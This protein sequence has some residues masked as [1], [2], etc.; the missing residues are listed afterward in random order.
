MTTNG[1]GALSALLLV[2]GL[3][4]A[5][6]AAAPPSAS[7]ASYR[8]ARE[9]LQSAIQAAGGPS[10][11]EA[12][13]D[14]TRTGTGKAFAQGQSVKIDPPYDERPLQTR[15]VFDFARRRS[16][17]DTD[18]VVQGVVPTKTRAVLAGDSGFTLNAVTN[19]AT[20]LAPGAV[21]AARAAL[22]RDPAALLLT[23]RSRADTL[24]SLGPAS[25][26][27]RPQRVVTF[28]DSDGAQIALYVDTGTN[29]VTKYETL[30]D[31]PVLGDTLTEV[32]FS[33]YRDVAGVK[34]PFRVVNKT[35]G[36]VVQELR[37]TEVRANADPAGGLF[38]S[39]A[40]AIA[41]TPPGPPTTVALKKLAEGVFLVEGSSHHSLAVGFKDHVVLVEAPLGDERSQAIVAALAEAFPGKPIRYVVPTHFH[42]DHT[43]GLRAYMAAGATIVT[44]PG[45]KEFLERLAAAPHTVKPDALVRSPRAPV[46]ETFSRKRVF[47]DGTSTLELHDIGPNP[48]VAEAVVAYLPGPRIAFQSD[49]VGLPADGP[50]PPVTPAMADFVAKLK[51]LGLQV[52]TITGGHG[53]VGTMDEV[54]KAVAAS[55]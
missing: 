24:R 38:E 9:V 17:T 5:R 46:I 55:K 15:S 27:G 16:V 22:R 10:A 54:A 50:L 2:T 28:A 53:R 51:T 47:T 6:A 30:A 23:A 25:C 49:L 21:G 3:P 7:E 32:L 36:E 43:P 35:G 42:Y 44:T 11:L 19:V 1:V 39:P 48:H 40:G 31:N 4:E 13:K 41:G 12:I 29:L 37:Y 33:D 26:D 52:E 8:E 45:N 18:S 14:L 34:L 20:P